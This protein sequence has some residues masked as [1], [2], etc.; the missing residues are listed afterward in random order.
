MS[1]AEQRLKEYDSTK[2]QG[3][4]AE[5]QQARLEIRNIY[6]ELKSSAHFDALFILKH[7][8]NGGVNVRDMTTVSV[9]LRDMQDAINYRFGKERVPFCDVYI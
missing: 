8:P 3:L 5:L 6:S 1:T 4:E 2:I 7:H 9:K